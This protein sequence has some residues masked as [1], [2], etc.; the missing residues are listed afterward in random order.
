MLPTRSMRGRRPRSASGFTLLELIIV[1]S[2]LALIVGAITP[3]MG[4]MIRSKARA[5][6]LG[7]L[8]LLGAAALDHYADTGAY[9]SAA[10]GLLA[11]SV[12]GW[13]G[14]YLSGTT[15]DPWSGS[16]GYQVDGYGEVY[17]FS[18][19]GMQLTITSSGPDRTANTSDDIA[20]VVDATPVL[21]RRTLER[22]ATVNVAIT[23]YNAVYLATE[24]LPA[25]WS[26][27][28]AQLV[29]RGFLPLGGPE[30]EDAFGDPFVGD[31]ASAPLVR[32]T[33]SNL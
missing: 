4:T 27:A 31:P 33:S 22:M 29:S 11:S 26:A 32:V 21:R 6:T 3:A 17:R 7:E 28:Y 12:S 20:L 25:T 16:S 13:A 2:V 18:S 30:E 1:M 19:S 9:P 14:P 23:Q 15:D 24:P 10:T 5:G 8:E